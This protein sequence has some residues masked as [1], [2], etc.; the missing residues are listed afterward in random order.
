MR[1]ALIGLVVILMMLPVLAGAMPVVDDGDEKKEGEKSQTLCPVTGKEMNRRVFMDYNDKRIYFCS[2]ECI[3]EFK[4]DPRGY[5]RKME[6][7]GVVFA[8]A[9]ERESEKK[10]ELV[11]GE[12]GPHDHRHQ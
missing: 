4:K 5:I 8:K 12:D 6:K 11:P 1:H 9:P 3:E 2:P 10:H 7:T